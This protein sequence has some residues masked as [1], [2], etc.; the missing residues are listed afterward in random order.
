MG[1][2]QKDDVFAEVDVDSRIQQIELKRPKPV[3]KPSERIGGKYPMR[4]PGMKYKPKELSKYQVRR[5]LPSQKDDVFAEVDVDSRI[6]NIELKSR[7]KPV[8][9]R[10]ER[11]GGKYPMKKPAMKYRP[12]E[13]SKN[14]FRRRLV[15]GIVASRIEKYEKL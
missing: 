7:K 4:K 11:I 6:Q 3:L 15:K 14:S 13:V 12:K 5:R 9:T 2:S 8:Y 10:K 1:P